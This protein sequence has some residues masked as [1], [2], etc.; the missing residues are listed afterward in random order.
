VPRG[1]TN[2]AVLLLGRLAFK[3]PRLRSW[4]HLYYGCLNNINEAKFSGQ[5]GACPVLW[6]APGGFVS[7]MRR[8]Q[9]LTDDEFR[10]LDEAEFRHRGNLVVE[11]KPDSYGKLNGAI[12]AIDYGRP[13]EIAW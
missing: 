7:V 5:P 3:F 11:H 13:W 6:C 1:E 2:R 8:A 9:P 10:D 4:R 12:V